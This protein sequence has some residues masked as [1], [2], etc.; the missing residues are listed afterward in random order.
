MIKLLECL[1]EQAN[2]MKKVLDKGIRGVVI[3]SPRSGRS[4][5]VCNTLKQ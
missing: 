3:A 2:F 4:N 5:P 1:K